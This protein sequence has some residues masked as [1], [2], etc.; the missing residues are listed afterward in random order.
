[1]QRSIF[2]FRQSAQPPR[3]S[4]RFAMALLRRFASR[5]IGG[6]TAVRRPLGT[7]YPSGFASQIAAPTHLM[8][9]MLGHDATVALPGVLASRSLTLGHFCPSNAWP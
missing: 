8:S 1:M 5:F 9:S 4:A 6:L 3:P 2:P 7:L